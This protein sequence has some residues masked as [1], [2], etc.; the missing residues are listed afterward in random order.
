MP[1]QLYRAGEHHVEGGGGVDFQDVLSRGEGDDLG[2]GW[3]V[4]VE[5]EGVAVEGDFEE[6]RMH[7]HGAA[8][9]RHQPASPG[10]I[11]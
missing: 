7:G 6:G 10:T 2:G 8:P 9:R 3:G 1:L 11:V 4:G 5:V